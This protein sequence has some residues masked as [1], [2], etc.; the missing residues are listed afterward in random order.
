MFFFF[1]SKF[2]LIHHHFFSFEYII[3]MIMSSNTTSSD[4]LLTQESHPDQSQRQRSIIFSG[5]IKNAKFLSPLLKSINIDK[6]IEMVITEFG[7][8]FICENDRSIQATSFIDRNLFT[9]Y[10]MEDEK[11]P[12]T[13]RILS[14]HLL[15]VLEFLLTK[16]LNQYLMNEQSIAT[17]LVIKYYC[18][19]RF[20]MKVI[21]KERLFSST[22]Q[23]LQTNNL[24]VW[25]MAFVNRITLDSSVLIDFWRCVDYQ[26]N[27][28]VI[29][30][31]N[32]DPWFVMRTKSH[33]AEFSQQI[34]AQSVHVEHYECT[35]PSVNHYKMKSLKYTL[36]PLM[37]ANKI[38]IRFS[39][40]G[41]LNMQFFI[42]LDSV[43][44]LHNINADDDHDYDDANDG[45]Q[46]QQ[47]GRITTSSTTSDSHH[48][49]FVEFFIIPFI[50]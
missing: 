43:N 32:N 48:R 19:K 17:T 35:V 42:Q 22:I 2:N 49:C 15:N 5:E 47:R 44:N 41:L 10:D 1:K 9:K 26:A 7:I 4:F 39:S 46:Q 37:L 20:K 40:T 3:I 27:S 28:I 30:M 23:T 33:R 36:R 6:Y 11:T 21:S 34:D 29:E 13:I 14:K 31:N 12:Q 24:N 16:R 25:T 8:K 38:N 50:P 45:L 18:D